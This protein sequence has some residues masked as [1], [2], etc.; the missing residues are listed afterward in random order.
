MEFDEAAF[1][2]AAKMVERTGATSFEIE[3]SDPKAGPLT[4]E[5]RAVFKGRTIASEGTHTDPA[6]AADALVRQLLEGGLCM[7]CQRRVTLT[8]SDDLSKCF[9]RRVGGDWFRACEIEHPEDERSNGKPPSAWRLAH[10]LALIPAPD[11]MVQAALD[12]YF[13]DYTSPLDL[14][15]MQLIDDLWKLYEQTGNARYLHVRDRAKE[16]EFDGTKEE[17]DAWA[18]S[19]EGQETFAEFAQSVGNKPNRAERRRAE[20]QQ[21]KGRR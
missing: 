5:A 21:R 14:P 13:G 8:D 10:A 3:H 4:W 17:S 9:R 7:Y 16:G 19:P 15:T 11:N 2:A 6:S 12:G 18:A 20:R 1:M